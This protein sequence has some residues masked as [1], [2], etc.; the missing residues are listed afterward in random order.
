[1]G[2]NIELICRELRETFQRLDSFAQE[3]KRKDGKMKELQQRLEA[4]QGCKLLFR[5]FSISFFFLHSISYT[6]G[7]RYP[8]L[9]TESAVKVFWKASCLVLRNLVLLCSHFAAY[10][11]YVHSNLV[12]HLMKVQ[13]LLNARRQNAHIYWCNK[14]PLGVVAAPYENLFLTPKLLIGAAHKEEPTLPLVKY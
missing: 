8:S 7:G 10:L 5:L 14:L 4:G 12:K 3:V 11:E 6:Q 9:Q 2:C 13:T 1:L